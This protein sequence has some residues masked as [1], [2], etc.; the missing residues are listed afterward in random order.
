MSKVDGEYGLRS[1]VALVVGLA[2]S[3]AIWLYGSKA[4]REKAHLEEENKK[5]KWLEAHKTNFVCKTCGHTIYIYE[6]SSYPYI[7]YGCS[8]VKS[9]GDV[10]ERNRK[11]CL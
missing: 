1:F 2:G 9:E 7:C 6:N 11:K 10:V 3:F 4:K 5:T 8:S